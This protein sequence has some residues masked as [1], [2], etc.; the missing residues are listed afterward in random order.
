MEAGRDGLN[1]RPRPFKVAFEPRDEDIRR[2]IIREGEQ[3]L[4]D[5]VQYEGESKYR[6]STF[7]Q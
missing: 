6:F 7:F 3:A 1:W 5:L 2:T 4:Q